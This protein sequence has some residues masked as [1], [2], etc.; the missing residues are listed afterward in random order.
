MVSPELK[1]KLD[2]L[3]AVSWI[4]TQYSLV[5]LCVQKKPHPCGTLKSFSFTLSAVTV[6]IIKKIMA[7]QKYTYYVNI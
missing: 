6:P 4:E 2:K 1:N 5:C 3:L 7:Y